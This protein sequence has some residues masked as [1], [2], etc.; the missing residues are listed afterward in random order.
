[1]A[2]NILVSGNIRVVE[3]RS[4]IPD[5]HTV[6]W[7]LQ[8]VDDPLLSRIAAMGYIVYSVARIA[9]P[10]QWAYVYVTEEARKSAC[11]LYRCLDEEV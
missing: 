7:I 1:M 9:V 4:E 6:V 8:E 11:G 2:K 10:N 3:S 5:S